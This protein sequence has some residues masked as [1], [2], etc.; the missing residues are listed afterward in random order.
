M[1]YICVLWLC[2]PP[3]AKSPLQRSN[4]TCHITSECIVACGVR[5][6]MRACVHSW[7]CGEPS[8]LS[9][10][11]NLLC[12]ARHGTS[13]HEVAPATDKDMPS[14]ETD[15]VTYHRAVNSRGG[16]ARGERQ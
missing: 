12:Q 3:P 16:Q 10:N 11:W 5:P 13:L 8:N 2:A 7:W 6:R 14:L 9:H 1:L 15:I 4:A